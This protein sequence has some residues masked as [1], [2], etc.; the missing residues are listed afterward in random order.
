MEAEVRDAVNHL[1]EQAEEL[2]I[3][4]KGRLIN[5][6]LAGSG[7]SVVLG[8]NHQVGSVIDQINMMDK[9]DLSEILHAVANRI[10]REGK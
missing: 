4:E 6:L 8:N 9:D 2:F 10:F 3:E 7:L 5:K 1:L